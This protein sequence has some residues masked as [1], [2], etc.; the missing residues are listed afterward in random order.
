MLQLLLANFVVRGIAG[1][2]ITCEML[3]TDITY[4]DVDSF[5]E[6][7]DQDEWNCEDDV[8]ILYDLYGDW[9]RIFDEYFPLESGTTFTFKNVIIEPAQNEFYG[10]P[11]IIVAIDSEIDLTHNRRRLQSTFVRRNVG[12]QEVDSVHS[13]RRRLQSNFVRRNLGENE[14][15]VV[16][17]TDA[18]GNT[19]RLS[20]ADLSERV[21]GEFEAGSESVASHLNSCSGDQL[22]LVPSERN[23]GVDGGTIVG[24]VLDIVIDVA[25]TDYAGSQKKELERVVDAEVTRLGYMGDGITKFDFLMYVMPPQAILGGGNVLAY[26]YVK[27]RKSVYRDVPTFQTN[28]HELGHNMGLKHSGIEGG[29]SWERIYGDTTCQMGYTVSGVDYD[30]PQKCFNGPKSFHLGWYNIQ[31]PGHEVLDI[32]GE[33]DWRGK[34][35]GHHDYF[36]DL[37]NAADSRVIANIGSLYVMFNRAEAFTEDAPEAN[38]VVVTE[39]IYRED[40]VTPDYSLRRTN[41]VFSS[42]DTGTFEITSGEHIGEKVTVVVCEIAIDESNEAVLDYAEV[43]IFRN[44]NEGSLVQS[45]GSESPTEAP[46]AAPECPAE[47]LHNEGETMFD[48]N[49]PLIEITSHDTTSVTFQVVNTFGGDLTNTFTMYTTGVYGEYD[50]LQEDNVLSQ[51]ISSEFTAICMGDTPYTTVK[52]WAADSTGTVLGLGDNAVVPKCCHADVDSLPMP[53]PVAM[54]LFKLPC[55]CGAPGSVV[56]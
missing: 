26:A 35:V 4:G 20:A 13:N 43:I 6:W 28:I 14:A 2:D 19:P 54:Y 48:P 29:S 7:G 50:C 32:E 16:R 37:Y 11:T 49:A 33:G 5:L 27:G 17:V 12:E 10:M 15:L 55:V 23:S 31:K 3:M 42:G 21:F 51:S 36:N 52:V 46:T 39:V 41:G 38:T 25:V 22:T 24:G 40:G 1:L 44:N 8:G 45:C 34:L 47:L 56:E 30:Y 9:E 18:K 53:M